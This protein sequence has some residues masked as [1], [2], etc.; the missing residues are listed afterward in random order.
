MPGQVAA[1]VVPPMPALATANCRFGGSSEVIRRARSSVH[2][3]SAP[4]RLQSG[5]QFVDPVPSTTELP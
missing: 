4:G 2:L 5:P 3:R 1:L